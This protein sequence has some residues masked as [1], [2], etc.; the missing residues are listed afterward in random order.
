MIVA[1]RALLIMRS[2]KPSAQQPG[3][4]KRTQFHGENGAATLGAQNFRLEISPRRAAE[5]IS[6]WKKPGDAGFTEKHPDGDPATKSSPKS[7]LEISR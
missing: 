6:G 4:E 7:T 2:S 1:R 3:D 5:E